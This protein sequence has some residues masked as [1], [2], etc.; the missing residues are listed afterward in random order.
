M[1]PF[2][3]L[4][5]LR[6]DLVY[7]S[8]HHH[9]HFSASMYRFHFVVAQNA[10]ANHPIHKAALIG[11][12]AEVKRLAIENPALMEVGGRLNVTPLLIAAFRG[13]AEMVIHDSEMGLMRG[14]GTE[15]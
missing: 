15:L 2:I 1:I 11:H 3:H 4:S 5:Q 8:H 7:P 13:N 10:M 6:S 12:L 9:N 14:E